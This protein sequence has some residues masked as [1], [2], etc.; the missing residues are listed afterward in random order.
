MGK[1]DLPEL[2]LVSV[3][4][5]CL[6]TGR[7]LRE[8]IESV[9]SQD[10]PRIEYIVMDGGSTDQTLAILEEYAGR[11]TYSS[12]PDAGTA[13]AVN[14]GFRKAH[15]SIL[16]FLN[17]DD[18]YLPGAIA[19]AVGALTSY[20]EAAVV[21]G[22]AYWVDDQSRVLG[23]Y[24]TRPFDAALLPQEC[25]ICQP[26]AFLR[27]EPLAAVGMLDPLL[28]YSFDYDLWIRMAQAHTMLKI[29]QF[30]A[31]SRMHAESKTL[32]QRRG[33]L[34]ETVKTLRRHFG[35]VS[36]HWIDAY[37]SNLVDGKDQFFEPARP[38]ILKYLF[39]LLVGVRYNSWYPLRFLS[40]WAA[41]MSVDGLVRRW[42][43][44][45]HRD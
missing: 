16:A 31:T 41:V 1:S 17:A 40:D 18:T 25:F 5:P 22:D 15:G 33:V 19:A 9:L 10:Y 11:L 37:A 23:P 44:F 45:F 39:S 21:Y 4:T 43:A 20:P 35:Y 34:R 3:I 27:R 29:E 36:F 38:S 7:F 42:Y 8:T 14:R 2:P 30:W 6:N 28:R 32:G 26:A 13:D 12:G 24:P